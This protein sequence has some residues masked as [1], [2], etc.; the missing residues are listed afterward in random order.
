MDYLLD[1][2]TISFVLNG[3]Q[4]VGKRLNAARASSMTYTSVVSEGELM[5]G[6]LRLGNERRLELLGEIAQLLS[7]L[8]GVLPVTRDVAGKYGE[9][10]RDLAARGQ[11]IGLNDVWIGATALTEGLTVVT[12]DQGFGRI[13]DLV[14]EDWL[15]P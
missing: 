14:V 13:H 6:A 5:Y 4:L 8:T 7:D 2:S 10:M 1:T 11:M 9:I 15:E 3:N 12:S